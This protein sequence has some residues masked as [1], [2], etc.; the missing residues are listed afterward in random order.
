M[1]GEVG[2]W[3]A[4]GWSWR[5]RWRRTRFEWENS[6]EEEMMNL[7]TG[8]TL[9]KDS[10]D[11]IEWSGDSKGVFSVKSAYL[12]L[13]NSPNGSSHNV[14]SLLLFLLGRWDLENY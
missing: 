4:L 14:F 3:G 12:T 9:N 13:F 6:I 11:I 2:S 8:K 5:L 7:I 1:V 10:E